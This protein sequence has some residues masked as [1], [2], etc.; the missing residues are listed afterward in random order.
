VE[1]GGEGVGILLDNVAT[2]A[3]GRQLA[4]GWTGCGGDCDH[5]KAHLSVTG[6]YVY[7]CMYQ[8]LLGVCSKFT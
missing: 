7:V 5:K 6:V 4:Q 2:E 1:V 3:C 8:M